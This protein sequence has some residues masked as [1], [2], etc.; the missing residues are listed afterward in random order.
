MFYQ[1]PL[2]SISSGFFLCLALVGQADT[3]QADCSE[4]LAF[5]IHDKYNFSDQSSFSDA[6]RK[7]LCTE[8]SS[9][10]SNSV[11]VGLNFPLA[12]SILGVDL[13]SDSGRDSYKKFCDT[14]D[15]EFNQENAVEWAASVINPTIVEAWKSCSQK[16]GF[17]CKSNKISDDAIQISLSWQRFT[18]G[19]GNLFATLQGNPITTNTTCQLSA[20]QDGS[21]IADMNTVSTL[22][23]INNPEK[24]GYMI[25]NSDRGSANCIALPIVKELTVHEKFESCARG[26]KQICYTLL[27]DLDKV[28]GTLSN[29][30]TGQMSIMQQM[31]CGNNKTVLDGLQGA[32]HNVTVS[33][34]TA[35]GSFMDRC[36]SSKG[37]LTQLS[38]SIPDQLGLD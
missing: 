27:D 15:R 17:T 18:S 20:L 25:F 31:N 29:G 34:P 30:C 37:L 24:A 1:K 38:A 5:G 21:Q 12:E 19:S 9:S 26:E 4:I 28:D 10:S 23:T 22:C 3:V 11:G 32:V 33:C 13:T 14:Y 35:P 2:S 36:A 6:I 16:N 7:S 8:S